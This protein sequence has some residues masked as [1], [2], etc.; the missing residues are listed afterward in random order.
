MSDEL[1]AAAVGRQGGLIGS[2][3]RDRRAFDELVRA[4]EGVP[5][6]AINVAAKAAMRAGDQKIGWNDARLCWPGGPATG[7][8]PPVIELAGR[9]ARRADRCHVIASNKPSRQRSPPMALLD[10]VTLLAVVDTSR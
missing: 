2:G 5:R 3:F 1:P 10:K 9:L 6:D 4:S 7:M 8:A